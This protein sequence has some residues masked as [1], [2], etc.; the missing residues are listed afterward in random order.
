M[1]K[2]ILRRQLQAEGATPKEARELADLAGHM[3]KL[4]LPH[5]SLEAKSE[6]AQQLGI[7]PSKHSFEKRLS[8]S[9]AVAVLFAIV[10]I[11]QH[12][13]PSSPLYE[14]RKLTH[15]FHSQPVQSRPYQPAGLPQ[16][17]PHLT[18]VNPPAGTTSSNLSN[19]NR[20]SDGSGTNKPNY[21]VRPMNVDQYESHDAKSQ[22]AQSSS[23][24]SGNNPVA[25][26]L[27]KAS[28]YLLH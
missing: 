14:V 22:D 10:M 25:G 2:I 9:G 15:F 21:K 18:L 6:I 13:S 7:K 17:L 11:S 27:K 4:P 16:P 20:Q 19:G 1:K 3:D 12:A 28:D 24:D 23:S 26:T 8:L 5:L